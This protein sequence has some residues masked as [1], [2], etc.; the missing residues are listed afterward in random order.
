MPIGGFPRKKMLNAGF[1]LSRAKNGESTF[2]TWG[3]K[4]REKERRRIL[5]DKT[6]AARVQECIVVGQIEKV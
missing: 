6:A 3:E 2:R 5:Q 4:K 1:L